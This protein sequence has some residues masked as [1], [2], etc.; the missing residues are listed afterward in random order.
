[1]T[2]RRMSTTRRARIFAANNG[3]C[4]ICGQ[5]ID[6]TREAWQA[7]H[8]IPL[9]LSGDD[10]DDNI[11]PAHDACHRAKTSAE[12]IPRI[13]KAKRVAAKH[14]GAFRPKATIP[15]SKGTRFKRKLDGTVVRRGEG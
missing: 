3:I 1:M 5:P 9:E 4:H 11:R 12:D 13:A 6:G 10:S 7:D 2:R 15:G 14:T 8:V